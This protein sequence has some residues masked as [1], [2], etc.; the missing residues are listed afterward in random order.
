MERVRTSHVELANLS[1]HTHLGH[2]RRWTEK[3]RENRILY[4]RDSA[5]MRPNYPVFLEVP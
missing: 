2:Y 5:W 4:Q 1:T 3:G